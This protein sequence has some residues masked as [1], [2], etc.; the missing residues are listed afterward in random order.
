[1]PQHVRMYRDD[2]IRPNSAWKALG[3]M[4]CCRKRLVVNPNF[5]DGLLGMLWAARRAL[6]LRPAAVVNRRHVCAI[7]SEA[8]AG[9]GIEQPGSL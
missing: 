2:P 7:D 5:P 9:I 3:V 1:M 8:G 6:R 4:A